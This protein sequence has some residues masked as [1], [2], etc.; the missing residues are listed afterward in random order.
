[1]SKDNLNLCELEKYAKIEKNEQS[2]KINLFTI[3]VGIITTGFSLIKIRK[4]IY[5]TQLAD[6]SN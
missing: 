3:Y 2:G 6:I 5:P 4:K 1:M